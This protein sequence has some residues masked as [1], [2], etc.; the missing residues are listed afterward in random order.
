MNPLLQKEA[1]TF[2]RVFRLAISLLI[3]VGLVWT[4]Q[5]LSNILLPFVAG[6][7]GAYLLHPSVSYFQKWVKLVSELHT[8]EEEV[9]YTVMTKLE[10]VLVEKTATCENYK[11]ELNK[12]KTI[13]CLEKTY[14]SID[15]SK[16]TVNHQK[17]INTLTSELKEKL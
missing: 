12:C 16:I 11:K 14:K 6:F 7:L 10:K 3:V 9:L 17:E 13:E 1:Y 8:E 4:L 15:K 5:Y 2:D